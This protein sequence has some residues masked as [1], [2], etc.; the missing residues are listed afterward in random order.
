MLGSVDVDRW[1]ELNPCGRLGTGCRPGDPIGG[2]QDM[3]LSTFSINLGRLRVP[4]G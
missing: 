1:F 3:R 4:L 2:D